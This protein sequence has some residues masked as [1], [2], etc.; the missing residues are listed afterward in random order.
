[1]HGPG[2]KSAYAV[3]PARS[4]WPN[5]GAGMPVPDVAILGAGLMG[6]W[7]AHAA[8]RLGARVVAVADP[9]MDRARVLAG[10]EGAV[11][12]DPEALFETVRPAVVHLCS[13]SASHSALI[14]AAI[15][16]G[17]HVFAEKPLAADAA[18]T[19][20][21][22]D[23]A[24]KADVLLC[25]VHQY[26]FQP[27]LERI[28]AQRRRIGTLEL[29]EMR[30][31]S[32]GAINAA[33][34]DIPRIA[35]DILPHPIAIAQRLWP[36]HPLDTLD[37]NVTP[38]GTAGWQMAAAVGSATLHI[39]L[40]LAARPTEASLVLYGDKGAWEADLFH[41]YARFRDGTASRRS[42]ALRP[43]GDALSI[44]R[45]ASVNMAGR[46]LRQEPAY[47]G[48]RALMTAFYAATAGCG[49][50]P[51]GADQAIAVAVL[52]DLFLSRTA[53][54]ETGSA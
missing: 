49:A 4:I 37:W 12:A 15:A 42:K 6:R 38:V 11:F 2:T 9:D 8:R 45:H 24:Q 48:L 47:P 50:T 23:L 34:K 22:C 17:I 52:R 19:R 53:Q 21:L 29:V 41:G 32:A 13:P 43:F 36:D 25:P 35:A 5:S 33:A 14:R 18:E 54:T 26:A 27:A 1:M 31:F 3:S 44:L 10:P 20:A 46:A 7:H 51:I 28:I 16:Q 30:Y 40:S 39:T